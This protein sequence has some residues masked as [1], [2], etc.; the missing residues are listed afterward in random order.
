MNG[1]LWWLAQNT[2]TIGLA[3][4]VVALLCRLTPNRPALHHLLWLIVMLKFL[5]PPVVVWPWSMETIA[6]RWRQPDDSPGA[7]AA[8]P[9]SREPGTLPTI[10]ADI[11]LANRVGSEVGDTARGELRDTIQPRPRIDIESTAEASLAATPL[12]SPV[13]LAGG[14]SVE[15][16]TPGQIDRPSEPNDA[17]T[18]WHWLN[19]TLFVIW[20]AG[21]LLAAIWQARRLYR[22]HCL[23]RRA[24]P[25]PAPLADEVQA[26]AARLSMRPPPACVSEGITTPLVW[27]LVRL[28][29]LWPARLAGEVADQ[30]GVI[31]HELAHVKRRDHWTAWLSLAAG[32]VWWWNPL[33]W[34]VRRRLHETAEMACDAIAV[35]LL[36]EGRGRYA[37]LLLEWSQWSPQATPAPAVLGASFGARRTFRRRLAM[38]L[39]DRVSSKLSWPGLALAALLALASLPA[40]AW[41]QATEAASAADRAATAPDEPAAADEPAETKSL[42]DVVAR[43]TAQL[44]AQEDKLRRVEAERAEL[45]DQMKRLADRVHE[46]QDVL[47]KT[48]ASPTTPRASDDASSFKPD[49]AP[50]SPRP[51]RKSPNPFDSL[52]PTKTPSVARPEVPASAASRA[53]A[54]G[55]VDVI[56]LATAYIDAQAAHDLAKARAERVEKLRGK[57]YASQEQIETDLLTAAT[58]QRKLKLL[59]AIV[60][61][62]VAAAKAELDYVDRAIAEGILPKSK[63]I[64]IE[65]RLR[66]LGLIVEPEKS[67]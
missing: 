44:K 1:V 26:V 2:V 60:E 59:R 35:E 29:L 37:E 64:G 16:N 28:M 30:R 49:P 17:P 12:A 10:P 8:A 24:L 32:C 50:T 27:S 18:S 21:A 54:D 42:Q 14:E 43:L 34:L 19:P 23:A 66:V 63:R 22:F 62:E 51:K 40:W 67:K 31:A 61:A 7:I 45:M 36:P 55:A 41:G 58:A 20:A 56:N 6:D 65:A 9:A 3:V 46:L 33:F 53:V 25:A 11:G 47:K 15:G 57:G 5:T 52:A 39:S 13:G 48:P 38:I 4:V